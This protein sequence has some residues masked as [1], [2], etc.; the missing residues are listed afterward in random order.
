M[1]EIRANVEKIRKTIGAKVRNRRQGLGIERK[2]FA[3]QLKLSQ[4]S[5]SN[6]ENGRQSIPAERLWLIAAMLGCSP[7]DLLPPIPQG[8]RG[9]DKKVQDMDDENAKRWLKDLVNFP[10]KAS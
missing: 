9:F 3:E 6:I 1:S 10:V 8:Y 5:I 7:N 2:E 4:A